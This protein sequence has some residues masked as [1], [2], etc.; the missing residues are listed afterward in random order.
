MDPEDRLADFEALTR[1]F[2]T[3]SPERES[4]IVKA[5]RPDRL[6]TRPFFTHALTKSQSVPVPQSL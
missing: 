6:F 1:V 5:R 2:F 3:K 4:L